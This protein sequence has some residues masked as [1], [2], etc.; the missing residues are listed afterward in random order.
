MKFTIDM[1]YV[2][3]ITFSRNAGVVFMEVPFKKSRKYT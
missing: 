3:I 1:L 2:G